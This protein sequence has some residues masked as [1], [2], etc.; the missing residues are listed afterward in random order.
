MELSNKTLAWLVLAAIVVSLTG[1]ILSI[2]SLNMTGLVT[3]NT[4]GNASVS[5]TT[6]TQLN[7]VIASLSF[8][9]GS[10]NGSGGYNCTMYINKTT[11]PNITQIGGCVGFNTTNLGGVLTLQNDGNTV[12]NVTLNFTANATDFIGGGGAP[13]PA[14]QFMFSA[15]NNESAS[16]TT[17]YDT[18]WTNV[19]ESTPTTICEGLNYADVSDS[20]AVG[21]FVVIPSNTPQGSKTVTITAQGT[22]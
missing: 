11:S 14:P 13:N 15:A 9:S 22:G 1:T 20:L 17:L 4:T 7:F 5:I 3:Y 21:L 19:V 8:G 12:I 16:C 2:N 10:V 18:S 6:Q